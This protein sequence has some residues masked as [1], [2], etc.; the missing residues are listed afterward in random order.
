MKKEQWVNIKRYRFLLAELITRDLKVKYRR[1]V[2]GVVWSVLNPLLMM[3]VITAVFK[4]V[5]RFEIEN[6]PIYY[7]TGSLI[8]NFV[9]EATNTSMVSI[10]G[11]SSLIK[12][13]YIPKYIFPLEKCLF[14]F[15]NMLFS[16]VAVLI[17]TLFLKFRLSWTFFLFPI[18]MIY[19]LIFSIG[20]SLILSALYIFFRDL[21][22][23]YSVWVTAWMYLT[24]IIYPLSVLERS[25]FITIIVKLNPLYYYVS[26]F[27]NV[28]MEGIVPGMR[29]NL[30]CIGISLS[31]FLLGIWIFKKLQDR[32]IL[33]I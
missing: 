13:V 19:T 8:F 11:A 23:L 14:S 32:F 1:S 2:L 6:F 7:L 27:R 20:L 12:K 30:I 33:H 15:I 24:P 10:L 29:M 16:M 22:H 21:G 26:Y 28:V 9:S 31:T 4:N 17:I 25:K 3:V 5:F 18:P